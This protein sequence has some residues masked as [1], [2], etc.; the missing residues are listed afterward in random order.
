MAFKRDWTAMKEAARAFLIFHLRCG[1]QI[2][3]Y[4]YSDETTACACN[5]IFPTIVRN[6]HFNIKGSDD[7]VINN[8]FCSEAKKATAG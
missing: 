1:D 7:P 6:V 3:F 8:Q 5:C 4:I 2:S